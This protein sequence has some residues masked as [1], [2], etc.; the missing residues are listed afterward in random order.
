MAGR[1]HHR[2][3]KRMIGGIIFV[4]TSFIGGFLASVGANLYSYVEGIFVRPG[5]P[6]TLP[7][8]GFLLIGV[9]GLVLIFS[10]LANVQKT[11]G[12]RKRN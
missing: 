6:V 8:I 3:S 12:R 4:L 2:F 5:N 10:D 11:S 7:Q 1:R 9:A